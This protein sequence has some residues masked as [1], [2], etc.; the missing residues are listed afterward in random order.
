MATPRPLLSSDINRRL[1]EALPHWRHQDGALRRDYRT[2][3]W[4]ATLLAANAIAHL[5]ELA[6]HH[7][8][9]ELGYDHIGIRL[10][11]HSAGGVTDLDLALAEEIERWLGWR[12]G[13]DSALSGT[14]A[15]HAYLI[16]DAG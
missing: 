11:T 3:G 12:P 15:E 9:L 16:D 5:A 4:R 6:W 10:S 13:P 8:E 7:P 1:N 14:P 2:S